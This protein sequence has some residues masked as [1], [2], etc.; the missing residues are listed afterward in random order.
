M[1]KTEATR[2][3]REEVIEPLRQLSYREL[4]DR[5]V[6]RTPQHLRLDGNSGTR[7][8]AEV[9]GFWD[10]GKPGR[11]RCLASIDDGRWRRLAPL[12]EGF[13]KAED[14]SFIGE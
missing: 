9:Q 14:G 13:V 4:V 8:N 12:C 10:D 5:F 1:D 3:L 6:D 2:L 7:Y 11:L